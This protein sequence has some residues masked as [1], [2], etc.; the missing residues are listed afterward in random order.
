M[1]TKARR[2]FYGV[3][4]FLLAACASVE[5]QTTAMGIVLR[6]PPAAPLP[7]GLQRTPGGIPYVVFPTDGDATICR[8]LTGASEARWCHMRAWAFYASDGT[9]KGKIVFGAVLCPLTV[10]G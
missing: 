8:R 3:S 4:V 1:T 2:V 10:I 7:S 9:P 5:A 6:S